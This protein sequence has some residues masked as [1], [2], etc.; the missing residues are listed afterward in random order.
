MSVR[1]KP[2]VTIKNS[3]AKLGQAETNT[4]G[5]ISNYKL[6]FPPENKSVVRHSIDQFKL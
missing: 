2:V 4:T 6:V 5:R 3:A 1:S